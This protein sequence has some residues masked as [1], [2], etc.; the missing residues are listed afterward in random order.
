MDILYPKISVPV[1][2]C[3]SV[4]NDTNIIKKNII[5]DKLILKFLSLFIKKLLIALKQND[6]EKLY[7]LQMSV[8]YLLKIKYL[9]QILN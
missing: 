8:I 7:K 2:Y 9:I 4:S 5:L 3:I 1:R 6:Q